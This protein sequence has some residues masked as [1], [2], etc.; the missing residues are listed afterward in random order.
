MSAIRRRIGGV[1]TT[2][3]VYLRDP[4]GGERRIGVIKARNPG[5]A[6]D[7]A[8]KAGYGRAVRVEP[9]RIPDATRPDGDPDPG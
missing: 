9:L 7:L 4:A 2:Y 8:R 3:L 1:L 6:Q 5:H